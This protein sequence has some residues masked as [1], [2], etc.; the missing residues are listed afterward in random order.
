MSGKRYD[1]R[2]AGNEFERL[3][4][5]SQTTSI[6]NYI[7]EFIEVVTHVPDLSNAHYMGY[8]MHGLQPKIRA[9]LRT[10]APPTLTEA[11]DMARCVEE[12]ISVTA[13]GRTDYKPHVS[14]GS[15]SISFPQAS[16]ISQER[17]APKTPNSNKIHTSA[18]QTTYSSK[19]NLTACISNPIY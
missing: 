6:D 4:S 16:Y 9:R 17:W 8:F 7:D 19:N 10:L 11:M 2:H 3:C 14:S 15:K 13:S 12:E 18:I 5:V 1:G